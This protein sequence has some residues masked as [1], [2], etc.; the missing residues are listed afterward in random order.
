MSDRSNDVELAVH[1]VVEGSRKNNRPDLMKKDES[2]SSLRSLPKVPIRKESNNER[3]PGCETPTTESMS[4]CDEAIE[5]PPL[6]PLVN[7][8]V[9]VRR[10][11]SPVTLFNGTALKK[12]ETG[13]NLSPCRGILKQ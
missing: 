3:T 7:R 4:Q 1:H 10:S 12:A 9:V 13:P 6:E 5:M 11:L 8:T 2:K